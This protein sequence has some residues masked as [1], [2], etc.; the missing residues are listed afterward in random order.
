MNKRIEFFHDQEHRRTFAVEVPDKE[1][2]I[3]MM[4]SFKRIINVSV[5][6]AHMVPKEKNYCKKT[7]RIVSTKEMYIYTMNIVQYIPEV[8]GSLIVVVTDKSY[9]YI[10]RI[11]HHSEF[12]HLIMVEEHL[13]D[14]PEDKIE[15]ML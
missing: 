3:R 6:K 15:L 11:V 10:F 14:V 12:V 13:I 5:G 4:N 7:G 2:I 8:D 1:T 9:D